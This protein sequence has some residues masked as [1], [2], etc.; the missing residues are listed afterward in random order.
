GPRL[1]IALGGDA[2]SAMTLGTIAP[3]R[4]AS[5]ITHLLNAI[6]RRGPIARAADVL[7]DE[8]IAPF[9]TDEVVAAPALAARLAAEPIGLHPLRGHLALG[10]A[11]AFGQ[12]D[13]GALAE[14]A[15]AA[16]HQGTT[17]I[18]PAPG[19]ALLLLGLD[20][21][22]AAR[23]TAVAGQ[24]G[25]IT[26]ADDPRRRIT[27][28]AGKPA[29]A[30]AHLATRA[31]AAA[32]APTLLR[33][34]GIALHISGC[35]KGC[36]H[37]APAPLTIVGDARGAG[38]VRNGPASATPSRNVDADDILAEIAQLMQMSEVAHG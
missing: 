32:I 9:G 20:E 16:G 2:Q 38:I 24:V 4:A 3:T 7:R 6:A 28:C 23:V 1:H 37:P 17:G 5:V 30:S 18:R 35:P 11:L 29:C 10:V 31:L 26:R 34:D 27:A 8:G 13:A 33:H 12:A 21:S 22:G 25:F 36:A 14:L 19:R 15:R